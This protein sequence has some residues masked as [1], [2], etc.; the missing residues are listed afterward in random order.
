MITTL[1]PV[2]EF[3]Y[4][5][6][7][8]L[9][10]PSSCPSAVGTA[11]GARGPWPPR[12]QP[13]GLSPSSTATGTRL[14]SAMA[15]VTH[16]SISK[17]WQR[18]ERSLNKL[19]Y[20]EEDRQAFRIAPGMQKPARTSTYEPKEKQALTQSAQPKMNSWHLHTVPAAALK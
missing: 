12:A 13:P 7:L 8:Q 19:N 5:K 10:D 15:Q 20:L 2:M 6:Q 16:F 11:G 1:L 4:H 17:G 14:K 18:R 9:H 3:P